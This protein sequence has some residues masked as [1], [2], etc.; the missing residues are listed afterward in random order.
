MQS[1]DWQVKKDY[2]RPLFTLVLVPKDLVAQG[3]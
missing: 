1:K 2:S 3:E